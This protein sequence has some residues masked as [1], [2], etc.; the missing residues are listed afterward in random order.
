MSDIRLN[1]QTLRVDKGQD[2]A[3]VMFIGDC[4]NGSPQFEKEKFLRMIEFC[5]KRN[6]Y[7]FLMGDLLEMATRHSVGAGVYEQS[8]P[9]QTQYEEMLEWLMPLA[10]KKL[11]LGLLDGNHERR[12]YKESGV[13]ISRMMAREFGTRYLGDACWNAFRVGKQTYHI[14]TLHGRSGARFDGTA[15]LALERL[16]ASFFG[17]M[18]ICG[19]M[20]KCIDSTVLM[21]RV[22]QGRVREHKKHLLITGSYLSYDG[23]YGQALGL[24]MSKLGSPKV[25]FYASRKD[26]SVSW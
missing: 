25:K 17:D 14:Y 4:H 5:K 3:S 11:L 6:R 24:P 18:V 16:S 2:Y 26:I 8:F 20:H 15:L 13:N 12:A 10:E 19:H 22:Y 9:G 23:S 1:R 7:V 21:Q